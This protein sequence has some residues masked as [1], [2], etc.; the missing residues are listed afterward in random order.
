MSIKYCLL[1]LVYG[2]DM[3]ASVT[4][5]ASRFRDEVAKNIKE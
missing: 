2:A 4:R 3:L 1:I 5:G